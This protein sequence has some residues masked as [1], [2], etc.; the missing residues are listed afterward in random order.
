MSAAGTLFN[1]AADGRTFW[2]EPEL[3]FAAE[4]AR[5][6]GELVVV[7]PCSGPKAPT[8]KHE[9]RPAGELYTGSFHR[10]ARQHAERLGAD[11]I[12]I[13]S[14]LH[15]LI[16]LDK[17]VGAYDIKLGDEGAYGGKAGIVRNQAKGLGLLAADVRVAS[18][19][20]NRYTAVL[21]EAIPG[22]LTPLAG[23][24]GIGDQ[25]GRLNRLAAL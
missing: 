15:G 16:T 1:V 25:R 18:F 12:L 14:A 13:L 7:I 11:R 9:R 8:G 3:P 21:A 20:P 24:T 5:P 4:V 17:L 6:A 2:H 22:L 10:Y 19:C 23:A